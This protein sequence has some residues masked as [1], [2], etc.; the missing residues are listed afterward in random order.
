M[1]TTENLGDRMSASTQPATKSPS[2]GILIL[3][4]V[5]T[6]LFSPVGIVAGIVYLAK[7][8]RTA[9]LALLILGLV[10]LVTGIVVL[11]R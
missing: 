6:L 5:L 11:H 10:L 9:G 2:T 7:G 4:V 3:L 8:S 1:A